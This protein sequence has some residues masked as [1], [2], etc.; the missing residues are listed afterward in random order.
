MSE[1]ADNRGPRTTYREGTTL[2]PSG[3]EMIVS[4]K[5]KWQLSASR[6]VGYPS[7][8]GSLFRFKRLDDRGTQKGL[9]NVILG[10]CMGGKAAYST[11]TS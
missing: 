2:A 4:R 10:E 8:G 11:I 3:E 7:W 6:T 1:K 9:H 5:G